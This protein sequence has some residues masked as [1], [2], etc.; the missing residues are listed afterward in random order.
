MAPLAES[1]Q[2]VVAQLFAGVGIEDVGI[3]AGASCH[4]QVIAALC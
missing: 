1:S 3:T 2:I 4:K